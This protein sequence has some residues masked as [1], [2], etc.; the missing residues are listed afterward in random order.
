MHRRA[1][2]EAELRWGGGAPEGGPYPGTNDLVLL[3]PLCHEPGT[4][5]LPSKMWP[6]AQTSP[7]RLLK[8]KSVLASQGH[9]TRSI[10]RPF[11]CEVRHSLPC[12]NTP[13]SP[14]QHPN[15]LSTPN[16]NPTDFYLTSVIEWVPV[17]WAKSLRASFPS[18]C[19]PVCFS[20]DFL[21]RAGVVV[22]FVFFFQ[23]VI[24]LW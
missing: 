19:L 8:T 15:H 6:P 2:G 11:K 23:W 4:M 10:R 5:T 24:L 9:S 12:A 17:E 21:C 22:V 16:S 20:L 14:S 13:Q 3:S 18:Q 1:S 7:R